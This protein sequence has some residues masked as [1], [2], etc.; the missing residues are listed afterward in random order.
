MGFLV[1]GYF[2][3]RPL[4]YY[5]IGLISLAG[6]SKIVTLLTLLLPELLDYR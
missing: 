3:R 1:T 5:I 4:L 2:Y 6:V